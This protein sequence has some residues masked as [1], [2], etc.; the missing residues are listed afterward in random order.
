[1]GSRSPSGTTYRIIQF[2]RYWDGA[3]HPASPIH[4]F[5]TDAVEHTGVCIAC[6]LC[7]VWD[8][9]LNNFPRRIVNDQSTR[10]RVPS[11]R[12]CPGTLALTL[13]RDG[14]AYDFL[15]RG[16]LRRLFSWAHFQRRSERVTNS[17]FETPTFDHAEN[18]GGCA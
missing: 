12:F 9:G 15:I 2:M 4:L 6:G 10:W 8:Q 17:E 1:M 13:T 3:R 18:F 11:V 7:L 16:Y 14:R 5:I